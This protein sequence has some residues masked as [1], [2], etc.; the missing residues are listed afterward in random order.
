[1]KTSIESEK[2]KDKIWLICKKSTVKRIIKSVPSKVKR[3]NLAFQTKKYIR[4]LDF[5]QNQIEN[6]NLMPAKLIDKKLASQSKIEKK[7]LA[8]YRKDN[9]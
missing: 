7:L 1:M 3:K 8:L 4:Y 9:Q 2:V 5:R 6:L